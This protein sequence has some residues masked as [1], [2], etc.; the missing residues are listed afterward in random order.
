MVLKDQLILRGVF[1]FEGTPFFS[2]FKG[3]THVQGC[4]F[5]EGT[6]FFF[7]GFK[8]KP[9]HFE[10]FGNSKPPNSGN[11]ERVPTLFRR[12]KENHS[13]PKTP[14]RH[15]PLWDPPSVAILI[16]NHKNMRSSLVNSVVFFR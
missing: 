9:T 11:F 16:D 7:C 10:G 8:V 5:F 2:G 15:V 13:G 4:L 1:F 14:T 12:F 6:L 3:P